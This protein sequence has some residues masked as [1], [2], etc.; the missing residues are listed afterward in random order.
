MADSRRPNRT[1]NGL[2]MRTITRK[3]KFAIAIVALVAVFVILKPSG[4]VVKHNQATNSSYSFT[5]SNPTTDKWHTYSS[6]AIITPKT[7]WRKR[8]LQMKV[9]KK[10]QG[11]LS[12]A[13]IFYQVEDGCRTSGCPSVCI[14]DTQK[15][16]MQLKPDFII[17]VK[18]KKWSYSPVPVIYRSY[19]AQVKIEGQKA[20]E[21]NVKTIEWDSENCLEY[22]FSAESQP[23]GSMS[24][25]FSTFYLT[26]AV[27][28]SI[29]EGAANYLIKSV[30]KEADEEWQRK[31]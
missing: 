20:T 26:S 27:A 25:V 16:A 10:L 28:D 14:H 9:A 5:W 7:D 17:T 6:F 22:S 8:P 21:K 29:A 18:P 31:K 19:S 12:E 2:I 4:H 15:E 1:R 24:G 23:Q 11:L 13:Q 30:S 3:Q